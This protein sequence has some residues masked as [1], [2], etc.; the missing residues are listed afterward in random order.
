MVHLHG[1]F[2][3]ALLLVSTASGGQSIGTHARFPRHSSASTLRI[4]RIPAGSG[5]LLRLRGSCSGY[6]SGYHSNG[7]FEEGGDG[8]EGDAITTEDDG[9]DGGDSAQWGEH[10]GNAGGS[11]E[12]GAMALDSAGAEGQELN[13]VRDGEEEI[14]GEYLESSDS[15]NVDED[16]MPC[17]TNY[18]AENS[19]C[20]SSF[21][22]ALCLIRKALTGTLRTA[23]TRLLAVLCGDADTMGGGARLSA[24]VATRNFGAGIATMKRWT[25]GAQIP[26]RRTR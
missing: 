21:L 25:P 22:I 24:H 12:G 20:V 19:G 15:E 1:A 5:G 10:S 8:A 7:T 14:A 3:L 16:G 18:T 6:Y 26:K 2:F 11:G 13:P 17:N 4:G 23:L 9:M